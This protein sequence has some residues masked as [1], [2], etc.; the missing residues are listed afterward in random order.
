MNINTQKEEFSYAYIRAVA[1]VA[2]YAVEQKLRAMDNAGVDV[3]IEVPGEIGEILFP[4]FDAQVKCTSSQ[5][6]LHN[7]YIKF[8]PQQLNFLERPLAERVT[9]TFIELIH[10]SNTVDK[11][12]LKEYLLRLRRRSASRYRKFLMSLINSQ[13]NFYF[14]W[15]SVNPDKGG[16][17]A[18]DFENVINTIDFINKM[19]VEEPCEYIINGELIAA[20]KNTHNLE[21][22]DFQD[23]KKYVG[24]ANDNIINNQNIE[25]IIGRLY[26]ARI[27]EISSINPATGEEKTEYTIIDLSY[28]NDN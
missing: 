10:L 19:E 25:L 23:S 20:N 2:G 18:L 6:V 7:D 24:K 15:G 26:S 11:G 8:H 16:R 17:A 3:T 5:S 1:S 4:K 13:A 22:E 21:I 28:W 12:R 9:E 14:D 27:Q